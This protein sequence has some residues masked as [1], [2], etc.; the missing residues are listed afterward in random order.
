MHFETKA[1]MFQK[2]K[3]KLKRTGDRLGRPIDEGIFDVVLYL[4]LLGIETEAS[5]EGHLDHGVAAPWIDFVPPA[6][7]QYTTLQKEARVCWEQLIAARDEGEPSSVIEKIQQDYT[8][9]HDEISLL[10]RD[11]LKPLVELLNE[12]YQDHNT[13]YEHMLMLHNS[14]QFVRLSHVGE[15]F[16]DLRGKDQRKKHLIHYQKEMQEFM[17]FLRMKWEGN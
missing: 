14:Y 7:K 17:S 3:R 8:S 13:R 12:F 9:I 2:M 15:L 1:D 5:C 10:L 4:N 16:Q 11:S 6:S